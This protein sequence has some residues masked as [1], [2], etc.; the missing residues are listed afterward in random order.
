MPTTNTDRPLGSTG[1]VWCLKTF[2][3]L[4]VLL[5]LAFAAGGLLMFAQ[6]GGY[7]ASSLVVTRQL[8]PNAKVLPRY[9]AAVFY[10]G[11]VARRVADRT[12]LDATALVPMR[13]DVV[14]PEDSIVLTVVGKDPDAGMA[15]RLADAGATA[16]VEELNRGGPG[17]GTF[18]VQ[19]TATVPSD[20][21]QEFPPLLAAVLG[22]LVGSVLGLSIVV[23]VAVLRRPV[24]A[25]EDVRSVI[26]AELIGD[27]RLP[28]RAREFT[29]PTEVPGVIAV[30]RRM[31]AI[32][33]GRFL[34][35]SNARDAARRQQAVV[36]LGVALAGLRH[37]VLRGEPYLADEVRTLAGGP[38]HPLFIEGE[39]IVLVDQSEPLDMLRDA[40]AL[41]MW[42]VIVAPTGI[43]AARLRSAAADHLQSEV[44]GVVLVDPQRRLGRRSSA[45]RQA[46]HTARTRVS[47]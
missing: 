25:A 7:E 15:A 29:H 40:T 35:V 22:G 11:E 21:V 10:S 6:P 32:T 2:A 4:P 5:A 45:R 8:V 38:M 1:F 30:A 24:V 20:P 14:T 13:L 46:Q 19:T 3:W 39:P 47:L 27:L 23:L 16:F 12:G 18:S 28:R 43:S 41:P 42:V 31:G 44:L 17:V 26:G 36:T 33:S 9:A 37:T 34:L